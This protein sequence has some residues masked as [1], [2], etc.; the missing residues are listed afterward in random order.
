MQ[1]V[2]ASGDE[3]ALVP[4]SPE[5]EGGRRLA[6]EDKEKNKKAESAQFDTFRSIDT[7]QSADC[8]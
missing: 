3:S 5:G 4:Y 2:V 6:Y 8:L 1:D 7:F